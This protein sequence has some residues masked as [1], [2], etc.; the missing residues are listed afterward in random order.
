LRFVQADASWSGSGDVE[1]HVIGPSG[2][3]VGQRFP[4]GCESTSNRTERVVLQ[5][6]LPAGTYRVDLEG[7]ACAAGTPASIAAIASVQ[8]DSGPKCPCAFVSV[9]VPGTVTACPFTLP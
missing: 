4:A 5:G 1:I 6:A 8:S 3:E 2:Q 7:R 9:P